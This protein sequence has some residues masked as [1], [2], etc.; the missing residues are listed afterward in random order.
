MKIFKIF[1]YLQYILFSGHRKGHGIH[2][3]FIFQVVSELFRNKIDSDIVCIIENARKKLLSDKR[4]IKVND[5]GAGQFR[6]KKLRKVSD[7]VKNSAISQKYGIL[8]SNFASS[9]GENGVVELG[10]SL[11]IS[12][13]YLALSNKKSQVYSIEGCP[14]CA[15]IAANSFMQAN[16]T[17]IELITGSFDD[18]VSKILERGVKPGLVFIDGDHRKESVERYF[19]IFLKSADNETVFIF[20]DIHDSAEMNDAWHTIINNEHVTATIDLHRM[21]IVFL[22]KGITKKSYIVR[23]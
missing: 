5:L 16:I 15:S 1:N 19:N 14:L 9:F 11:G 12:T 7:I 10:T 17:N 20:D 21:G 6:K 8:L 22:K 2:S 18:S 13:M 4:T 23:F 3:P